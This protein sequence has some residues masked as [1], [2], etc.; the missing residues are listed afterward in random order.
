MCVSVNTHACS[1]IY[2]SR[3]CRICLQSFGISEE[4]LDR[5][6]KNGIIEWDPMIGE[7]IDRG[8]RA[9]QQ[10]GRGQRTQLVS[11]LLHGIP[12]SGKTALAAEIAR[13]SGIPF[14][15]VV[16][17]VKM[18][19]YGDNDKC[20]AIKKV[21]VPAFV[22]AFMCVVCVCVC[23]CVC[24]AGCRWV[25][26]WVGVGVGVG[27]CGCASLPHVKHHSSHCRY[28]TMHTSQS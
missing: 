26:V 10:T 8:V 4:Q 13:Q 25:W 9:A 28:L 17:P 19:G 1:R 27:G 5:Y 3:F 14:V 15:K 11:L 6:V 22:H 2:C 23:V 24:V 18:I 12:G 21:C 20:H 7:I 16:T